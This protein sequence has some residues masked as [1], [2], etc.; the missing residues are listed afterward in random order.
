MRFVLATTAIVFTLGT[1]V[2]TFAQAAPTLTKQQ[3]RYDAAAAGYSYI[4]SLTKTK[5]GAWKGEG[6]EG[7]FTVMPNG[8]VVAQK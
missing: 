1:G 8:K 7:A 2:L 4:S 5:D 6:H 3:A